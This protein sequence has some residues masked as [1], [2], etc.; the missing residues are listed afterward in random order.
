METR[1]AACAA[2]ARDNAGAL[3]RG[4]P[5][6]PPPL[7]CNPPSTNA[8]RMMK[9]IVLLCL[10]ASLPA[11]LGCSSVYTHSRGLMASVSACAAMRIA[12]RAGGSAQRALEAALCLTLQRDVPPARQL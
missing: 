2:A 5:A 4:N 9:A 3:K 11:A 8:V 6:H 7:L 1:A 10:A 12:A